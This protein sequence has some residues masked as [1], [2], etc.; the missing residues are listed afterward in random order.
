VRDIR[1]EPRRWPLTGKGRK[2]RH[3]PLGGNTARCWTPTCRTRPRQA[4]PRRPPAVRQPARQQTQPRRDR[5]DHPQIPD[6]DRDP[7]LANA[8]I[9]PHTLRHSKAMHLYEAGIPLPYI[10]DILGHVDLSTTEIYARASTEAKRRAL[11]AAYTDIVTDDLPEWNQ[12]PDCSTGSPTCEPPTRRLC[13]AL[14]PRH[15]CHQARQATL[16]ITQHCSLGSLCSAEHKETLWGPPVALLQGSVGQLATGRSATAL[17]YS[18]THFW[19]V[20]AA[21]ALTMRS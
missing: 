16:R 14:G 15:A 21:T 12:T 20:L 17:Q 18:S 1:L 6:Q 9:S 7:T 10:R 13:A 11:E 4:R 8:D 3:V 19:S 5:L 2:T